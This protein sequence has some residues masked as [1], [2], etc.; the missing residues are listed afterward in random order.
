MSR[1]SDDWLTSEEAK[2]F[3]MEF[4]EVLMAGLPDAQALDPEV[5]P[6][7]TESEV[8]RLSMSDVSTKEEDRLWVEVHATY[9][10]MQ[11]DWGYVIDLDHSVQPRHVPS[12]LV[13]IFGRARRMGC[14]YLELYGLAA[15]SDVL[16]PR[17]KRSR[18][19]MSTSVLRSQER[20]SHNHV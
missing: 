14:R 18:Q 1:V 15:E 17:M 13:P 9:R 12:A 8:M 3:D 16:L 2:Q 7:A 20:R 4:R 19:T 11:H 5:L 6:G 10:S